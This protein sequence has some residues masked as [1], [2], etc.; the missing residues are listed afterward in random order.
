MKTSR[1]FPALFAFAFAALASAA[2]P[3]SSRPAARVG[4]AHVCPMVTVVARGVTVPHI[5][6]PIIGPGT[7]SV[8]ICGK[9]A[10]VVGTLA[11]CNGAAPDIVVHGS[12]SVIIGGKGAA[13]AGDQ[14]A[15]GG[16]VVS[17]CSSVQIGD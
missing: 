6:G 9:A 11:H 17:G 3:A 7:P 16:S 5:G 10:A 12:A 1:H 2:A 8:T 4:D 13:R 14:T 15:H